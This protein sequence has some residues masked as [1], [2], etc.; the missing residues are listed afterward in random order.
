M[1][2]HKD[3]HVDHGLTDLQL[4]YVLGVASAGYGR[5]PIGTKASISGNVQTIEIELPE[6]LGTVP[7]A[8]R[9]PIVGDSPIID[10]AVVFDTRGKRKYESRITT[11]PT[12]QTNKVTVIAGPY[13]GH[14]LVLYTAFGGPKAPKEVGELEAVIAKLIDDTGPGPQADAAARTTDQRLEALNREL[15]AS[16]DFW[17]THA[18]SNEV[19]AGD[20]EDDMFSWTV[21]FKVAKCWVEDGFD[22]DSE[23]ALDMLS[24]DLSYANIGFE[25]DART[26]KAPDPELI[27]KTMGYKSDADRQSKD[28]RYADRLAAARRSTP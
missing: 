26:I 10:D 14:D 1:I 3:S 20:D 24:R 22:L 9:G 15:A 2:K 13:D 4:G 18:L 7:C 6:W 23:R 8:L 16:R 11:L 5:L 25:L 12:I 21:E 19:L 27:A 28:I 17:A